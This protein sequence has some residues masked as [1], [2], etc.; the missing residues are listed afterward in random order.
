MTSVSN[1]DSMD[2][3]PISESLPCPVLFRGN[4]LIR[5]KEEND[6]S[7]LE[8]ETRITVIKLQSK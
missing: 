3:K 2:I 5:F 7:T 6:L 4:D 8:V 1:C